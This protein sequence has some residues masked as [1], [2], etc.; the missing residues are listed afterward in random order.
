LFISEEFIFAAVPIV[1]FGID[2]KMGMYFANLVSATEICNGILKWSLRTP[3]P[4]WVYRQLKNIKGSWEEDYSTPSGHSMVMTTAGIM[5]AY[6][7]NLEYNQFF[8]VIFLVL[9]V[10][11]SRVYLAMHYPRDILLS[12]IASTIISITCLYQVKWLETLSLDF[13]FIYAIVVVGSLF[14]LFNVIRNTV[15][16]ESQVVRNAWQTIA[17]ENVLANSNH[18]SGEKKKNYLIK[19]RE[20]EKYVALMGIFFGTIIA[21]PL[22]KNNIYPNYRESVDY[23]KRIARIALGLF[24]L[25]FPVSID[26]WISSLSMFKEKRA[27]PILVRFISFIIFGLWCGYFA[28]LLFIHLAID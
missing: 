8:I 6:A 22:M 27:I 11:L 7:T 24:G 20:V 25:P 28:P 17:A 21:Y 26:M 13:A 4:L 19:P 15:T 12:W 14:I 3:R 2:V 23:H 1:V 5:V 10:G 18:E 9:L 16:V